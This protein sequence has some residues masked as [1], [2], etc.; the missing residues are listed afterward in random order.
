M[1]LC[2]FRMSQSFFEYVSTSNSV[3]KQTNTPIN[4]KPTPVTPTRLIVFEELG[5]HYKHARATRGAKSIKLH[6][7]EL[8]LAPYKDS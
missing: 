8:K 3:Y 5:T 1:A 2:L 7:V 4:M 6:G